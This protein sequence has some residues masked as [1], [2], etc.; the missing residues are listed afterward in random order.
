MTSFSLHLTERLCKGCMI[1]CGKAGR[2]QYPD[3]VKLDGKD[4][5]WVENA[6]HLGHTLH[7]ETNMDRD[8]KRARG[9]FIDRTVEIREELFFAK[10]EQ[11]MK[12]VQFRLLWKY[13]LESEF[14]WC[15]ILLQVLGLKPQCWH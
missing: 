6:D 11:V 2:V 14:C 7:Q 15:R 1:F 3:P 8:S 13:A 10:P 12:A 4:L 5:P 9:R